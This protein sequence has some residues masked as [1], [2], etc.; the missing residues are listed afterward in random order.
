MRR[1]I[2][3]GRRRRIARTRC[4]GRTLCCSWYW[5][6]ITR[7][8]RA[9][10]R[11]RTREMS[12]W[13]TDMSRH[14]DSIPPRTHNNVRNRALTQGLQR[15]STIHQ[16][17]R[18]SKSLHSRT[19]R[20]WSPRRCSA[21]DHLQ[22]SRSDPASAAHRHRVRRTRRQTIVRRRIPDCD[23]RRPA[24]PASSRHPTPSELEIIPR[25]AMVRQPA[26][27]ISRNPHR[28]IPRIIAPV[29]ISKWV[30]VGI[31]AIRHPHISIVRL[32]I[33]VATRIQIIPSRVL[34]CSALV[35]RSS[36]C[37]RLVRNGRI[38]IGIPLVP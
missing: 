20:P 26:P 31:H 33:P 30:P 23:N 17:L 8:S 10:R 21:I 34:R 27:R 4:C 37:L 35:A 38:S 1:F 14:A 22:T 6:P 36:L 7:H 9:A 2:M 19:S 11:P 32:R 3:R 16:R 15:R 24:Q 5:S 29:P 13:N 18:S 12:N 25:A 28:A